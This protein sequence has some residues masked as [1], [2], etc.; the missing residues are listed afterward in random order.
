M[1]ANFRMGAEK[2]VFKPKTYPFSQF[3]LA[4]VL[5]PSQGFVF[6]GGLHFCR[7]TVPLLYLFLHQS[8]VTNI[9]NTTNIMACY[10][11]QHQ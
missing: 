6:K 11:S 2:A 7:I 10:K 9:A 1:C 8:T 4:K 5:F 3:N